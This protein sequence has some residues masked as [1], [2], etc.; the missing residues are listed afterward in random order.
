MITVHPF[1]A[2]RPEVSFAKEVA[3]RPYDVLNSTEARVKLIYQ[4]MLI[5]THK[6]YMK[7][8]NKI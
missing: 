4:R 8:Q 6:K 1:S 5:Y 7:K 2:L 3:S